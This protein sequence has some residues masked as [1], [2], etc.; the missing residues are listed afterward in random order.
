MFKFGHHWSQRE[1][2]WHILL[3]RAS[4]SSAVACHASYL[5]RVLCAVKQE[6]ISQPLPWTTV[7]TWIRPKG[8]EN[9]SSE[10]R[11]GTVCVHHVMWDM[12][13]TSPSL[14]LHSHYYVLSCFFFFF[15]EM[16]VFLL[17]H[18]CTPHSVSYPIASYQLSL[19]YQLTPLCYVWSVVYSTWSTDIVSLFRCGLVNTMSADIHDLCTNCLYLF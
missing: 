1:N 14:G 12:R 15:W 2:K 16:N 19:G 11:V 17:C 4:D 5:W 7:Q 8:L 10:F 6:I 9:C 3:C 13:N 18:Y